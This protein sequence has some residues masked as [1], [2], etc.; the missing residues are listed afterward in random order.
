MSSE[1][2]SNLVKKAKNG[3]AE[4]FGELYGLYAE[5]LFRFAYYSVGSVSMA[6]DCVSEAVCLAFQKI[7]S[8]KKNEA[9]KSWMFKILHNC[10]K[11]AQKIKYLHKDEIELSEVQNLSVEEKDTN[12]SISLMAAIK[13]LSAEE[14][15]IMILYYSEGYNSKEIGKMLGLKDNTVRSKKTR[16]L[17]KMGC[18]LE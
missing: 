15:D 12:E 11:K 3:S 14:R 13:K 7:T 5:D 6:E 9:F 16:A 10:C 2:V 18:I 4:A 17:E 8:L 1:N